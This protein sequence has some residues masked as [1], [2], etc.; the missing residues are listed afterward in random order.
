MTPNRTSITRITRYL[1][2]RLSH[3]LFAPLLFFGLAQFAMA[4]DRCETIGDDP[5]AFGRQISEESSYRTPVKYAS[6]AREIKL[7]TNAP[8]EALMPFAAETGESKVIIFPVP[9]AKILCRIVHATF[10]EVEGTQER[11]F[12]Q[13][14]KNAGQCFEAGQLQKTCLTQFSNDLAERYKKVYLE[15]SDG[16]KQGVFNFFSDALAQ[17]AAHEYAHHFLDHFKRIKAKEISRIDAE[18]EADYFSMVNGVQHGEAAAAMFYLFKGLADIEQYT[19]ASVTR[20][21]ESATCRATNVVNITGFMGTAPIILLDAARGGYRI[22]RNS[23]VI[24]DVAKKQFG[25]GPPA[26]DPRSCGKLAKVVLD[27]AHTELKQL[28][29]RSAKDSDLLLVKDEQMNTNRTMS[30]LRDLSEMA[31]KFR[32]MNGL[33]A[34]SASIVA[35]RLGRYRDKRPVAE[36]IDSLI[37]NK[38]VTDNL[39]SED[40]GRFL[41]TQG[42]SIFQERTD[43]PAQTRINR[44]YD[45][46]QR[47]VFYNARLSEAWASLALIAF[48]KGDCE[49]AS[50]F[51]SQSAATAAETENRERVNFFTSKMEEF[52]RDPKTCMAE[53][54]KFRPE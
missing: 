37:A 2:M 46:L 31:R 52:S 1:L 13:A 20:E 32:H 38:A 3:T 5:E 54:A 40:Y 21:Y 8:G 34:K 25:P 30:L 24:E 22:R 41:N 48:M 45:A 51:S 42:L 36:A 12:A 43:L 33:A 17:V 35:Q 4:F 6:L 47:A 15:R 28:Y 10:F 14:A 53:G 44:S 29:L 26:M 16:T 49:A 50:R 18:F 39:I 19:D 7:V 11:D 27:D 23:A 9:F